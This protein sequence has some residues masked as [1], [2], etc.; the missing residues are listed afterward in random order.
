MANVLFGNADLHQAIMQGDLK[1][2]QALADSGIN[3]NVT[4]S[5]FGSPLGLAVSLQNPRMIDIMLDHGADPNF[6]P[7]TQHG[8]ILEGAVMNKN[9]E[10][11]KKLLDRGANPNLLSSHGGTALI[12]AISTESLEMVQLLVEAGA[13]LLTKNKY[14]VNA[15]S[16]TDFL[17]N[18]KIRAYILQQSKALP[19]ALKPEDAAKVGQ[20]E[21]IR[22]WLNSN[23]G[24]HQLEQVGLIATKAGHADIVKLLLEHGLDPN[25]KIKLDEMYNRNQLEPLILWAIGEGHLDVVQTLLDAGAAVDSTSSQ[26]TSPLLV[27]VINRKA[28]IVKALLAAGADPTKQDGR[29]NSPLSYAKQ[30]DLKQIGKILE[31]AVAQKPPAVT[32]LVDA[33]RHGLV[34]QVKK[35]LQSGADLEAVDGQGLTALQL[36]VYLGNEEVL[37]L[38][39]ESGAMVEPAAEKSTW[40]M[41]LHH[42]GKATIIKLL[43]NA[44]LPVESDK[45]RARTRFTPM[46][47]AVV[48]T[49][50]K[51]AEA[52]LELLIAAGAD[53]EVIHTPTVTPEFQKSIDALKELGSPLA[54]KFGGTQTLLDLA[55]NNRKVLNYLKTRLGIAKDSYDLALE[56]AKLLPAA[57]ESPEMVALVEELSTKLKA[58]PQPWK[59]RKGVLSF[60]VKLATR[61]PGEADQTG[62]AFRQFACEVQARGAYLIYARLPDGAEGR[63][64]L[65]FFPTTNPAV[66][67]ACS[68]VNG[69]NYGL[70]CRDVIKWFEAEAQQHPWHLMGCSYDFIDVRFKTPISDAKA[71]VTKLVEFCPDMDEGEGN[72]NVEA[73]LNRSGDIFFWWD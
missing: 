43:L 48:T 33:V 49:S 31:K 41:A 47:Y 59:K 16:A 22:E 21:P 15:I 13:D 72:G 3:F 67:M 61:F 29:G 12:S 46:Q 63:T 52:I 11:V 20:V 6:V 73:E 5:T 32:T 38:L 65:L 8:S 51:E 58:K 24:K 71:F 55:A 42:A 18:K 69:D 4:D 1:K 60:W 19:A 64:E 68:G 34:D 66:P 23:P 37:K 10:I 30:A 40:E 70:S 7:L 25:S 39:I 56:Q 54:K 50:S 9:L 44:G 62:A 27:A 28:P 14:G 53:L 2:L 35:L 36:A 45:F 17:K 26:Q 57:L